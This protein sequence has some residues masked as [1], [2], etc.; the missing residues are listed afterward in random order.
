MM[1]SCAQVDTGILETSQGMM[2][3]EE[4][5]QSSPGTAGPGIIE[6]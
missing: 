1:S 2:D 5:R 6:G 4:K 3:D